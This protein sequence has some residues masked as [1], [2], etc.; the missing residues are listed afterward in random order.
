MS[1]TV[2]V[3]LDREAMRRLSLLPRSFSLFTEALPRSLAEEALSRLRGR[4]PRRSGA[5]VSSLGMRRAG[6][7]SYVVSYGGRAAPYAVYLERGTRPHVI[8]ASGRALVFEVGG[9]WVYAK[10]VHHPGTRPLKLAERT[11]SEIREEVRKRARQELRRT[12]VR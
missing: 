3:S 12:L 10:A 5:L 4:L 6:Q 1:L 7:S 9:T 8:S 11:A 2:R